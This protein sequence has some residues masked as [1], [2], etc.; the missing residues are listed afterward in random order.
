M[1]TK[2]R[3][4]KLF[5]YL[6]WAA[7]LI[8]IIALGVTTLAYMNGCIG[9]MTHGTFGDFIGGVVGSLWS[10]AA[11]VLIW[12][13][14]KSQKEELIETRN[15]MRKQN[16]ENSFYSLLNAYT[17]TLNAISFEE[18][19]EVVLSQR[20]QFNPN[21]HPIEKNVL[22]KFQY[23]GRA[24]IIKVLQ[25]QGYYG[26]QEDGNV[27]V[28]IETNKERRIKVANATAFHAPDWLPLCRVIL[29]MF[30]LVKDS[31]VENKEF[32]YSVLHSQVSQAELK[33]LSL[34]VASDWLKLER[35]IHNIIYGKVKP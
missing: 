6:A 23:H 18:D 25:D 4:D 16:F 7:I 31:D 19:K 34:L 35:E 2:N 17:N 12:I 28:N 8:G 5:S 14:Y 11:V 20:D 32:Y 21:R 9:G 30:E 10:L 27:T 26:K 15:V 13:T 29:R 33:V 3:S 22:R 24:A 1:G